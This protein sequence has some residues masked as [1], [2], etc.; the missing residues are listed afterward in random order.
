MTKSG[1]V[2]VTYESQPDDADF[3]ALRLILIADFTCELADLPEKSNS[4]KFT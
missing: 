3:D 2:R 1:D 4:V